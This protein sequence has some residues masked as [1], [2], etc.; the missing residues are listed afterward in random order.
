[1]HY[2]KMEALKHFMEIYLKKLSLTNI[3]Q[4]NYKTHHPKLTLKEAKKESENHINRLNHGDNEQFGWSTRRQNILAQDKMQTLYTPEGNE[5]QVETISS[6]MGDTWG[7]GKWGQTRGDLLFRI[8][9]EVVGQRRYRCLTVKWQEITVEPENSLKRPLGS[10]SVL[11]HTA[12]Q[13]QLLA[14]LSPSTDP[15]PKCQG[16][17]AQAHQLSFIPEVPLRELQFCHIIF[18]LWEAKASS[19]MKVLFAKDPPFGLKAAEK[20]DVLTWIHLLHHS[21]VDCSNKLCTSSTLLFSCSLFVLH[22]ILCSGS[23]KWPFC[24]PV[25]WLSQKFWPLLSHI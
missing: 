8:K 1:M 19:R 10:T 13:N 4:Q 23:C 25:M 21:G 16:S 18:N 9:Q 22:R 7:K 14:P 20:P 2:F 3:L 17:C 5:E 6:Q 11:C 12:Q 24:F 15:D